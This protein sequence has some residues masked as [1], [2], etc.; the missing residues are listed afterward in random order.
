[1][2][3]ESISKLSCRH[4]S[5]HAGSVFASSTW[6][7][8]GDWYPNAGD[9]PCRMPSAGIASWFPCGFSALAWPVSFLQ[10]N[11]NRLQAVD[12]RTS[13]A[14]AKGGIGKLQGPER[15]LEASPGG[16]NTVYQ[17]YVTLKVMLSWRGARCRGKL[18]G[19]LVRADRHAALRLRPGAGIAKRTRTR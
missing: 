1:M 11:G 14:C 7:M 5:F 6:R 19:T 12:S 16:R 9:W 15:S 17:A 13:P 10:R 2:H 3:G 18:P 8:P 4:W